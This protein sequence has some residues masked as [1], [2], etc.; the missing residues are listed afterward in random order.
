[1]RT[2]VEQLIH[3]ATSHLNLAGAR[4]AKGVTLEDIE[5][6]TRIA[7][8]FLEAIEAE[9][10]GKLPGGV[11]NINYIRQ[12]AR[13][14]GYDETALLGHYRSQMEPPAATDAPPASSVFRLDEALRTVFQYVITRGRS[15]HPA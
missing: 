7:Q 14:I 6:S 5:Q 13:V 15:H 3:G 9:D 10:F 4:N 8:R 2:D 11:Y 1:M 12:Y